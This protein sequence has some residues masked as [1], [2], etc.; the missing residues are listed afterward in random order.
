MSQEHSATAA[1]CGPSSQKCIETCATIGVKAARSATVRE[2]TAGYDGS[3]SRASARV[4]A[5]KIA[6]AASC[7]RS[8]PRSPNSGVK[9]ANQARP[10]G[11]W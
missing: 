3:A 11:G 10:P 6:N 2:V 8:Q 9:R 5:K 7:E 1:V 4:A